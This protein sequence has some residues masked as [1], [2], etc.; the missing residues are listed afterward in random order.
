MLTP[1][2]GGVGTAVLTPAQCPVDT[3]LTPAAGTVILSEVHA[4]TS[5][6]R[7]RPLYNPLNM[8]RLSPAVLF[9]P[10]MACSNLSQ[11]TMAPLA[12]PLPLRLLGVGTI[13]GSTRSIR[14][15][16]ECTLFRHS[17]LTPLLGQVLAHVLTPLLGQ[18]LV[19]LAWLEVVFVYLTLKRERC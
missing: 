15:A 8:P 5:R 6:V 14:C 11:R 2:L 3:V 10:D 19:T 9:L 7:R 12:A 4:G 16:C 17:V 18:V 13:G 1:P